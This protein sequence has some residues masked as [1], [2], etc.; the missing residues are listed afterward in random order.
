MASWTTEDY[1]RYARDKVTEIQCGEIQ[2][3]VTQPAPVKQTA[4][5]R[6]RAW[7]AANPDK[8]LA[9]RRR[10]TAARAAKYAVP[11]GTACG[12]C[13]TLA[14]VRND[15]IRNGALCRDCWNAVRCA[16]GADRAAT[17]AGE[18]ARYRAAARA[19]TDAMLA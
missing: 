1:L 8:V 13:G 18:I 17:Y 6:L 5:D 9:Q 16:E 15:T 2:A 3:P 19:V 11:N 12:V 14:G 7:R 10:A 4:P